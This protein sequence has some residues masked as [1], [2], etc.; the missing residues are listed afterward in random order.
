M[1]VPVNLETCAM[2]TPELKKMCVVFCFF[3]IYHFFPLCQLDPGSGH[4]SDREDSEKSQW[5]GG[6]ERQKC[7]FAENHSPT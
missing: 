5:H 2:S 3:L 7:Y 4:Q 1:T 6:A